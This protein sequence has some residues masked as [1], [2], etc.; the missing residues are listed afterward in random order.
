MM[1]AARPHSV[2]AGCSGEVAL[3]V[4][5]EAG[6]R[7]G[8]FPKRSVTPAPDGDLAAETEKLA[9]GRVGNSGG[10]ARA[11][12]ASDKDPGVKAKLGKCEP[13]GLQAGALRVWDPRAVAILQL[14]ENYGEAFA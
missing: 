12:A 9:K 7:P 1:S 5:D 11:D 6:E 2:L 13:P 10:L 14:A 4:H 3:F 8:G